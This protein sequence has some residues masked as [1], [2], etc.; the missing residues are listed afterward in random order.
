ML[1]WIIV[2]SLFGADLSF[3]EEGGVFLGAVRSLFGV[4]FGTLCGTLFVVMFAVGV[5]VLT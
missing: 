5:G 1:S 3:L 2:V 4:V